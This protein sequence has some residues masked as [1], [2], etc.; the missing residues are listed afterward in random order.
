[1]YFPLVASGAMLVEPTESESK[2]SLDQFIGAMNS[3][4]KAAKEGDTERFTCAP[5][6][7]PRK[8]LDETRAARVPILTA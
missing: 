5:R 7:A 8:R 1:V 4:A 6:F 2:L 3:L